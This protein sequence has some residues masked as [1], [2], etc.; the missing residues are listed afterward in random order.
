MPIS[1]AKRQLRKRLENGKHPL[2][3]SVNLS[4]LDFE[5]CDIAKIIIDTTNGLDRKY[6]VIEV[7]E[8]ALSMNQSQLG[9]AVGRLRDEGFSVWLDDFGSGYSSLNVLKDYSFDLLKIDMRFLE[10]F[11]RNENLRP[12][13]ETIIELCDVLNMKALA[14]GVE[15][16]QEYDFL[17]TIGCDRVQGY[18]FSKPV[19]RVTL[20]EMFE[21]GSLSV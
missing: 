11:G 19:T 20:N 12:I 16:Q 7:T 8:S 15:T 1:P 13:L 18:L 4:R 14:E 9:D 5:L 6:L 10:G 3:V 21:N 17:K 2:P